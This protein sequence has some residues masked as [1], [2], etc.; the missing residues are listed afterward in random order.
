MYKIAVLGDKDSIY[1]F[2]A[3]GLIYIRFRYQMIY[4]RLKKVKRACGRKLCCNIHS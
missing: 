2:V 3:L 1:G 4:L